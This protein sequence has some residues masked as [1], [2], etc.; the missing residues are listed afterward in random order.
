MAIALNYTVKLLRTI[1][2]IVNPACGLSW[3]LMHFYYYVH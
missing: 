2:A 1:R 3:R